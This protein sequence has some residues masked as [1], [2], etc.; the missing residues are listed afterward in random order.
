[1]HYAKR[2]VCWTIGSGLHNIVLVPKCSMSNHLIIVFV[3]LHV[4]LQPQSISV[5]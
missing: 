1:M 5:Q 4:Q 3:A 2:G